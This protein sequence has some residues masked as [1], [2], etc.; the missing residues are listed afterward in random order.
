MAGY[1]PSLRRS[2]CGALALTV[3]VTVSLAGLAVDTRTRGSCMH[4]PFLA[5]VTSRRGKAGIVASNWYEQLHN[6]HRYTEL[7]TVASMTVM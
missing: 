7:Y 6:S 1:D 3:L 4:Q 2:W 5:M